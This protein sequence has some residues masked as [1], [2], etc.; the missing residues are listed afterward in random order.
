M[1]FMIVVASKAQV[2]VPEVLTERLVSPTG[3][4]LKSSLV[5]KPFPPPEPLGQPLAPRP[6]NNRGSKQRHRTD[7]VRSSP[8]A[9]LWWC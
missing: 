1:S 9:A 8:P 5:R 3:R 2:G 6:W 7:V 4:R